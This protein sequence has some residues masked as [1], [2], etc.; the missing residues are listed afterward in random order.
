M[1]DAVL[2]ET[3][4]PTDRPRETLDARDLPP[5]QPLKTSLERLAALDDDVVFVQINDRT[6]QHLY[7]QLD[8]RGYRYETVEAS[9]AVVT[10]VWRE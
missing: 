4:A 8:E 1:E 6:P 10:V 7:P 2:S 9:E 3:A 5:P